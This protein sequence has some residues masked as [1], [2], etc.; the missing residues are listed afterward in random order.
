MNP[1][2]KEIARFIDKEFLD[3]LLSTTKTSAEWQTVHG[4]CIIDPDGWDRKNYQFSFN[5]ELVTEMEYF[6]RLSTSTIALQQGKNFFH[7][8]MQPIKLDA[9][10]LICNLEV[11]EVNLTQRLTKAA[12]NRYKET[13][14]SK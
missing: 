4:H 7:D 10:I 8:N 6:T 1:Q 5:E 11:D 14:Q 2:T 9:K 3:G 13:I 12:A